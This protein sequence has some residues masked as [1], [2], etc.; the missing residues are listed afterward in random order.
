[1]E[2][3]NFEEFIGFN[4]VASVRAVLSGMQFGNLQHVAL[5]LVG[6]GLIIRIKKWIV[7]LSWWHSSISSSIMVGFIAY[8]DYVFQH[9]RKS[10]GIII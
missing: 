4:K 2:Q 3:L 5:N 10:Y 1:M 7:S 9:Q 8:L 6:E